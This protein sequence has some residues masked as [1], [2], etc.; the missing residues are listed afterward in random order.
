LRSR[1]RQSVESVALYEAK[2]ASQTAQLD[3]MNKN[4]DKN[5]N[6]DEG[7]DGTNPP[8]N[9]HQVAPVTEE[10]LRAEERE[11]KELEQKK[12]ALEERVASMEKDLGGLLC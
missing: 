12:I 9:A 1:Y 5:E 11:I 3:R 8:A 10:Q 4:S 6:Q 2:V 7:D